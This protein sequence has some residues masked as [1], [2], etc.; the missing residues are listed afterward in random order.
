MKNTGTFS[1]LDMGKSKN[2]TGKKHWPFF[3]DSDGGAYL[4]LIFFWVV[5]FDLM[6]LAIS[7]N[8]FLIFLCTNETI[9]DL[10]ELKWSKKS[11]LSPKLTS[12]I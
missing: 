4:P 9:L 12:V 1:I 6:S 3:G 7:G 5:F 10:S 8:T 2:V 11:L